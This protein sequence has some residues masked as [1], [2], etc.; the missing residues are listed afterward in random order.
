MT[1][2]EWKY[3]TTSTPFAIRRLIPAKKQIGR[4]EVLDELPD[5]ERKELLDSL[6]AK[7]D[8]VNKKYQLMVRPLRMAQDQI[9]DL[10]SGD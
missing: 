10:P 1:E 4:G 7:W 6:K 5:G 3:I 9:K 8:S 2:Y